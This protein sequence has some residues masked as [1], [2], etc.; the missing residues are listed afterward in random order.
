MSTPVETDE[1][2]SSC[3]QSTV[4]DADVDANRIALD[5]LK[6]QYLRISRRLKQGVVR[7][8]QQ[9]KVPFLLGARSHD[10]IQNSPRIEHQLIKT[11]KELIKKWSWAL[12]SPDNLNPEINSDQSIESTI[13]E[14]MN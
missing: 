8:R 6:K 3:P 10:V 2:R 11:I 4:I 9:T 5:C 1:S 12:N 7:S 14:F 13:S